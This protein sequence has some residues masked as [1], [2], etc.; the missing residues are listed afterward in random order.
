M[1]GLFCPSPRKA[2][3]ETQLSEHMTVLFYGPTKQTIRVEYGYGRGTM[4]G[5]TWPLVTNE[6][7]VVQNLRNITPW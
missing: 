4:N 1:Y 3:Q 7:I 2:K 6:P 5:E